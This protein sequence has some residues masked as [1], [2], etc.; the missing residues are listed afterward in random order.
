MDQQKMNQLP[1]SYRQTTGTDLQPVTSW[2]LENFS[3]EER[4]M[5][6]LPSK[7]IGYK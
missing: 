2:Q 7:L 4:N 1:T 3:R 5:D 6:S